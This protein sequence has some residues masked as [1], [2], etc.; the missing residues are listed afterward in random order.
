MPSLDSFVDVRASGAAERTA[1]FAGALT[2]LITTEGGFLIFG[3][4]E[5]D[6]I[7]IQFAWGPP[8]LIFE[9]SGAGASAET[10]SSLLG[11]GFAAPDANAMNFSS[12]F[13]TPEP[14]SLAAIVEDIFTRELG[15]EHLYTATVIDVEED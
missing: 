8:A 9:V 13:G 12:Q 10:T 1:L 2:A 3:C 15:C 11:R 4:A 6:D 14:A 5:N 7:Y